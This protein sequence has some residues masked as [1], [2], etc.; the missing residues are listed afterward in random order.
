MILYFLCSQ[1]EDVDLELLCV[2][3]EM[4]SLAENMRVVLIAFKILNRLNNGVFFQKL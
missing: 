4:A 2:L 1:V 3:S